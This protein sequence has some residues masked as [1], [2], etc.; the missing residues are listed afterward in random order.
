LW[1]IVI[2]SKVNSYEPFLEDAKEMKISVIRLEL[3]EEY[4][5]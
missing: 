3:I 5:F 2:K 4:V 1:I